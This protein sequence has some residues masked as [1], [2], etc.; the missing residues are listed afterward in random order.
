M[1]K[2]VVL[3]ANILTCLAGFTAANAATNCFSVSL[4]DTMGPSLLRPTFTPEEC[5][6]VQSRLKASG[7]FPHIFTP[8]GNNLLYTQLGT[9]L[10]FTSLR[11][12]PYSVTTGIHAKLDAR[13]VTIDSAS[14]WV[15]AFSPN[16]PSFG[17]VGDDN[18][19][20]VIT[21][22]NV[23]DVQT[24]KSIG[25]GFTADTLETGLLSVDG[26]ASELNVVI[27]GTE[28]LAGASGSVR[29]DSQLNPY[30]FVEITRLSGKLCMLQ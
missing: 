5:G 29:V 30:G 1:L 2:K 22:W 15:N 26:R 14:V 24:N 20:A 9:P 4:D 18:M 17:L 27:G 21:Q 23:T 13:K 11:N 19:A 16:L 12:D 10:C 28:K 8:Q 7:K 6:L 25:K 3:T